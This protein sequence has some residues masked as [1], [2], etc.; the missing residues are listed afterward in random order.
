MSRW[1]LSGTHERDGVARDG[2]GPVR[3][4]QGQRGRAERPGDL[5]R[6]ATPLDSPLYPAGSGRWARSPRGLERLGEL[7]AADRP[8][9]G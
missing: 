5:G 8:S 4:V 7:V 6:Y 3:G 2:P 9:R 1:Q